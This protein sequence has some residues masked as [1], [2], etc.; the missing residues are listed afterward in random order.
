MAMSQIEMDRRGFHQMS[1]AAL[2]GVIAGVSV[3]CNDAGKPVVKPAGTME[4]AAAAGAGQVTL[5]AE[6]EALIMDEPH[7]CRGLNSCKGLGRD[8]EN[9]CA[10]QGTCASIADASCGGHN[11]CK[12]QGG[13][14]ENPGMNS[15]KGQGGCHVPLMAGAWQT[16]RTAF[17]TA[18]KKNGKT[19]GDAPAKAKK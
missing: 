10:G 12:G 9:A 11:E 8:K 15:C 16:A 18:M 2:T 7:T 5:S 6:A 19:F 17:E 14:G 3:G 1:L 13:C 4:P